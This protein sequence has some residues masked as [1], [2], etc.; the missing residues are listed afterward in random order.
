VPVNTFFADNSLSGTPGSSVLYPHTF[1]ALSAGQ[2]TFSTSAASSTPSSFTEVI[3][4]DTDCSGTLTGSDTPLTSAVTVN[5]GDKVC[6]IVKEMIAINAGYEAVN[7]VT[8]TAQFTYTNASPALSATYTR[9]DATTV[10]NAAN[11]GLRLAKTVDKSTAKSGDTLLYTIA[12]SNVSSG[13]VSNIVIADSTPSYTTF[14][15]AACGTLP[16][17]ITACAVS[18][19]PSS[20]STGAIKWTLTGS[21]ASSASGQV[22]FSVRIQ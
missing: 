3:F 5:A 22:T 18:T 10:S 12:Y 2:V 9:S 14:V 20:G 8:V 7:A 21:L 16:T 15:S 1:T 17:G 13:T 19:Q 11:S 6:I 4:R